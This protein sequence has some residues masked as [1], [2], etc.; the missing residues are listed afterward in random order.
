MFSGIFLEGM[1]TITTNLTAAIVWGEIRTEKPRTGRRCANHYTATFVFC[2]LSGTVCDTFMIS[3]KLATYCS[4]HASKC[5][6]FRILVRPC[7]FLCHLQSYYDVSS[8]PNRLCQTFIAC[9]QS[10]TWSHYIRSEG[11]CPAVVFVIVLRVGEK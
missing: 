8:S 1:R 10:E 11:S 4:P 7:V 6:P 9:S 2:F 3:R 5:G